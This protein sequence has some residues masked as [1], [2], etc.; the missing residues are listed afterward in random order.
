MDK[1]LIEVAEA[2]EGLYF[3]NFDG[4]WPFR[5]FLYFG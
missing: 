1:T 5:D 4:A 2:K 3:F